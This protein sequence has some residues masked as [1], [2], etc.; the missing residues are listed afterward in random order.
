MT[1]TDSE[2][3]GYDESQ[4]E[5]MDEDCII[6]D[7]NDKIIGKD[8]KVKCHL[9]EGIL[10]RAFSVLLF[11][12]DNKLLIQQR[13]DEKITFPSIWANSCC[14]H[15]LYENGEENGIEGAKKAAIRKL[16][17]ELGIESG[18][19]KSD[20]LNFITKMHYKAR[21]DEKWIEHEVDYI[22]VAKVSVQ[23][24]PNSNEI[25]KIA[26]VNN[27]EL[28]ELF[29]KSNNRDVKIGPWFR[30]IRDNFLDKIWKNIDNLD[31]IKDQKIHNMGEVK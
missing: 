5:M 14:S 6:V 18:K 4:K 8:S 11:N 25:Q 24:N 21:A 29:Q 19:I 7:N 30:L 26:Y 9:Y 20:D 17:Q 16:T 22:F 3:Q 2:L 31:N 27:K 23:I 15:P 28:D 12:L 1:S 13:A 10:H